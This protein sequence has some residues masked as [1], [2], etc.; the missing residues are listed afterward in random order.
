LLPPAVRPPAPEVRAHEPAAHDHVCCRCHSIVGEAAAGR[1]V[2]QLRV[3]R[4]PR[5]LFVHLKR[6]LP[7]AAGFRKDRTPVVFR[8]VLS[9]APVVERYGGAGSGKGRRGPLYS[10]VAMVE[11][12]GDAYGGHYICHARQAAQGS[13]P[14][15]LDER[16]RMYSDAE[17]RDVTLREV[18]CR[19]A[20]ILVYDRV[21]G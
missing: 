7:T 5:V 2:K 12:L 15:D 6:V 3:A 17:S 21:D 19:E 9:L 10:L 20:Y 4:A 8:P 13:G 14:G 18:L 11:H 16:W 1:V